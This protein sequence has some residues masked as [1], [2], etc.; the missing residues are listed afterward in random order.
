[1]HTPNIKILNR[2]LAIS[3]DT[4]FTGSCLAI[5]EHGVFYFI[6]AGHVIGSMM[7]GVAGQLHVYKDNQWLDVEVTPYFVRRPRNIDLAI[8]RTTIPSGDE[9]P[10]VDLTPGH[11]MVGQDL[12]FVGFPY[13]GNVISYNAQ[14][15]N[16][17]FPF[18]LVK[19]ATLAA[20]Q[21][22]IIFLDGHNNPGFSG[23]P[24]IYWDHQLKMQKVLGIVTGYINHS[25]KVGN[26]EIAGEL[27]YQE[28][29]GIAIGYDLKYACD[30]IRRLF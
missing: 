22:P 18:P 15:I 26:S 13:F 25:G 4:K 3:T 27:F 23:G 28:N 11:P 14:T 8:I 19:K 9:V 16:H 30:L 17:G 21:D 20:L 10:C 2:V 24:I 1:M 12:F 29:S 5:P 6:T 7:H